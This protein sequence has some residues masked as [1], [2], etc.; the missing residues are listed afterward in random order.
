MSKGGNRPEGTKAAPRDG[1]P[2]LVWSYFQSDVNIIAEDFDP[3]KRT[4]HHPTKN[5]ATHSI[6]CVSPQDKFLPGR[7]EEVHF[8]KQTK[9]TA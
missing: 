1:T 7:K 5:N 6:R 2:T 9:N 3:V 8:D 4:N